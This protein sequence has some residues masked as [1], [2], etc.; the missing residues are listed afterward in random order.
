ME[1][2]GYRWDEVHHEAEVLESRYRVPSHGSMSSSA[3]LCM[4]PMAIRSRPPGSAWNPWMPLGSA[5]PKG[6]GH[7]R[8]PG[9]RWQRRDAAILRRSRGVARRAGP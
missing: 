1:H 5:P 2:L 7:G 8:S 4:I 3:I 6:A 9:F